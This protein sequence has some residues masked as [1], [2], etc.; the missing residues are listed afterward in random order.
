MGKFYFKDMKGD[1][2][3]AYATYTEALL[4][5]IKENCG[6]CDLYEE[7]NGQLQ[8]IDSAETSE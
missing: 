4:G 5:F 2:Y 3:G 7:V 6:K 8:K 1:T